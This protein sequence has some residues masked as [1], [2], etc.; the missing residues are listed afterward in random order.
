VNGQKRI[1][2]EIMA[3]ILNLCNKPQTKT[4]IMYTTN[5]SYRTLQSYLS[6]LESL[7]LLNIHHSETKYQT[8]EKGR[9]L[10][11]KWS[12][13]KRILLPQKK[14]TRSQNILKS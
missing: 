4:R 13:L 11:E 12:E 2:L 1:Q 3:E 5:L 9:E 10:L 8:T 14:S 6:Q 7:A